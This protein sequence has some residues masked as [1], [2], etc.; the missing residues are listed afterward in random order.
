MP[1]FIICT[2]DRYYRICHYAG[3]RPLRFPSVSTMPDL[4][5]LLPPD[6]EAFG[7]RIVLSNYETYSIVAIYPRAVVEVI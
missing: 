6:R 1:R 4:I 2:R 3:G 5:V 7:N